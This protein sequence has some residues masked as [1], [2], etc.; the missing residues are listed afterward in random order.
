MI[1]ARQPFRAAIAAF[2]ALLLMVPQVSGI[3][4]EPENDPP[5]FQG[6]NFPFTILR[7]LQP[8]PATPMHTLKGGATHLGRFAGKVVLLNIWATWCPPCVYELPTLERLQ[9]AFG[10]DRFTVVA[11]SVDVG[12]AGDVLPFMNRIGLGGLP[13]YL[14]PAG[15]IV[16]AL[17]VGE[18]LPWTFVID[19]RGRVMGYLKGAADWTSPQ[20][21]AL[22]RYYIDRD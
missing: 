16:D 1:G 18:G 8:A 3:A 19:R 4:A 20:A 12:G 9:A 11:L 15:R 17:Q 22:V 10:G 21:R 13:V 7:P 5:R 6:H 2:A 14:D